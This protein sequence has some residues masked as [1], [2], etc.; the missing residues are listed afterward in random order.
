MANTNS[1]FNAAYSGSL[2]GISS[3][4]LTSS[5]ASTYSTVISACVEFAN[6]VDAR[7]GIITNPS[8]S[9][10]NLLQEICSAFWQ[11]RIPTS[12]L[13]TSD[14][15]PLVDLWL[16]SRA[17]ILAGGD[18]SI[19]SDNVINESSVPGDNASEALDNLASPDYAF[20]VAMFGTPG[21]R[22]WRTAQVTASNDEEPAVPRLQRRRLRRG[23]AL[24]AH[25]PTAIGDF[26]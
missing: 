13:Y 1:V 12:Q 22:V 9:E 11:S 16:A 6:A 3:R 10:I 7:V 25:P 20:V 23:V 21:L 14:V 5:A 26:H 4:W 15:I 18:G 24:A 19:G 2:A 8:Q 17:E